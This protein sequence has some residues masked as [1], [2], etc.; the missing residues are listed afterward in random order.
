MADFQ[1]VQ[2]LARSY[3]WVL[4]TFIMPSAFGKR[5]TYRARASGRSKITRMLMMMHQSQKSAA[6]AFTSPSFVHVSL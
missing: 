6:I 5:Y 2:S 4:A 3:L 1:L